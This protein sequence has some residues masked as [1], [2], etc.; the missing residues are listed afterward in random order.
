MIYNLTP[1]EHLIIQM[2]KKDIGRFERCVVSVVD[3]KGRLIV[4]AVM[5]VVVS[6]N[7]LLTTFISPP[8]K[9]T[10]TR[11]ATTKQDE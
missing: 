11:Q 4:G 6:T 3:Q 8:R 9:S 7:F 2:S 10:L 5:V 1:I